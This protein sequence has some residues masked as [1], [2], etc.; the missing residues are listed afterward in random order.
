MFVRCKLKLYI[1]G[2]FCVR[3]V[4]RDYDSDTRVKNPKQIETRKS[5][6]TQDDEREVPIKFKALAIGTTQGS[7]KI[8]S[9]SLFSLSFFLLLCCF[10]SSSSKPFVGFFGYLGKH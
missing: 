2:P 5:Y 4:V 9:S 7:E 6:P 8:V 3:V 1:W 10:S